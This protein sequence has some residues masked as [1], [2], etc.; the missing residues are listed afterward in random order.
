MEGWIGEV[1]LAREIPNTAIS[2]FVYFYPY[3]YSY[4]YSCSYSLLF[5]IFSSRRTP[6]TKFFTI[7]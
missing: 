2:F 7:S 3:P 1:V 4:S 6:K 5:L